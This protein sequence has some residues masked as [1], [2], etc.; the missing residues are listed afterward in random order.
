[1]EPRGRELPF[2]IADGI[3]DAGEV[4]LKRVLDDAC[5]GDGVSICD[6]PEV[7]E[8][9]VTELDVERCFF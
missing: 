1:M 7:F 9:V 2:Q 8:K 4:V 3:G 6:D 5:H